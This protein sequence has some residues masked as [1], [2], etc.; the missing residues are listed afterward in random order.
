MRYILTLLV[1]SI[2]KLTFAQSILPD[3]LL[4]TWK[5][6]NKEVYE[7]WD[8]L[9]EGTLK[10]F[11]Y[12]L[13]DG[14]MLISE[15]LDIRKVGKEIFYTATVINQNSGEP[16]DFKLTKS[17]SSYIFENPNHDICEGFRRKTK[18][19]LLQAA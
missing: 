16:V 9:N 5:M 13:N 18:R 1:L 6:E 7:N 12:K 14:Q 15:Y 17:D 4:G 10:G 11:S 2:G 8:K 19:I 3:F